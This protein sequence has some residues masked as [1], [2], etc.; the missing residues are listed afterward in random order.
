[1]L[2]LLPFRHI[3]RCRMICKHICALINSS[4]EL[5]FV[6]ELGAAGMKNNLACPDTMYKKSDQLAKSNAAWV[7]LHWRCRRKFEVGGAGSLYNL[8]GGCF[9]HTPKPP[10]A[11]TGTSIDWFKLPSVRNPDSSDEPSRLVFDVPFADFA[12]DALRD[13]I[14]GVELTSFT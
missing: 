14:I 8:S 9:F 11:S 6:I 3:V 1:M 7:N 4:R 5:A 12:V 2:L 13:L 10:T